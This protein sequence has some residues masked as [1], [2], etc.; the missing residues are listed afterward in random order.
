MNTNM[1]K[2]RY[3]LT[4]YIV[5]NFIVILMI[6]LIVASPFLVFYGLM[7]IVSYIPGVELHSNGLFPSIWIVLKFFIITAFVGI[8]ADSLFNKL[9]RKKNSYV[10]TI[11]ECLLMYAVFYLYVL[12]YSISS[13]DIQFGKN[14][15]LYVSIA[16]F[17]NYVL[18]SL[19]VHNIEKKFPQYFN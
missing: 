1:K 15:V 2:N 3:S 12:I 14:S 17:I 11:I 7:S 18:M 6:L 5:S 10:N 19:F 4:D 8:V 16:I 9:L 13:N